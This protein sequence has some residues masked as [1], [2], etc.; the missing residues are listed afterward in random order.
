MDEVQMQA[1]KINTYVKGLELLGPVIGKLD[2][3]SAYANINY[4]DAIIKNGIGDVLDRLIELSGFKYYRKTIIDNPTKTPVTPEVIKKANELRNI[5]LKKN[6]N[7]EVEKPKIN[8]DF[9]KPFIEHKFNSTNAKDMKY[10]TYT[11]TLYITYHNDS[12]Q[13]AYPNVTPKEIVGLLNAESVGKY[14]NQVIKP[15]HTYDEVTAKVG[16]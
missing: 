13:Y 1:E 8:P 9:S 15:N 12:R 11:N 2:M 10:A 14:I 7:V 6:E 5:R 16:K 3:L 4:E